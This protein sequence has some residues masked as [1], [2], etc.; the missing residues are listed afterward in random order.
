M[1][2]DFLVIYEASEMSVCFSQIEDR[3]WIQVGTHFNDYLSGHHKKLKELRISCTNTLLL[4][5]Q[6]AVFNTK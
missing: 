2:P 1:S 5:V 6:V 4:F 3:A